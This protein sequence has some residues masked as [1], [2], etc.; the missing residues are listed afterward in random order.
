MAAF[1]ALGGFFVGVATVKSGL[2]TTWLIPVAG[3]LGALVVA[4]VMARPLWGCALL[5][6]SSSVG[7]REIPS[8]PLGL[9][10]VHV[11][12]ALTGLSV[13]AGLWGGRLAAP[14]DLDPWVRRTI[15][16][17]GALVLVV[18]TA[19]VLSVDLT[20][21]AKTATTFAAG[22]LMVLSIGT[23]ARSQGDLRLLVEAFVVGS[24]PLSIQ[25]IT[26]AAQ[27]RSVYSATV[28]VGR[29]S[30]Y[31]AEPNGLGLFCGI[32]ML[33]S[34]GLW[35]WSPSWQ[36]RSV[37][38]AGGVA[39]FLATTALAASLSRGAWLGAGV[40]LVTFAVLYRPV[41]R[42]VARLAV[43][44][45][46]SWFVVAE[47]GVL[48]GLPTILIAR[49]E[50]LLGGESNP[51]DVRPLTWAEAARQ[52]LSSPIIG[53]GPNSFGVL[54]A[55][56]PSRIQFY[57]R[58]H[59]HNGLLTIATETGIL[60]VAAVLCLVL[61]STVATLRVGGRD[62]IRVALFSSL[63]AVSG[64]LLVDY[65]LRNPVLMLT[66]WCVL[67]LLVASIELGRRRQ[68]PWHVPRRPALR[69]HKDES[70]MAA[71]ARTERL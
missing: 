31:F 53:H 22:M 47:S 9:Q 11:L 16:S 37:S 12:T 65:P 23:C 35:I 2:A 71:L 56:W 44:G 41:L 7:N 64:H 61:F 63:V 8:G 68:H 39:G 57:P 24:L 49:A 69:P 34:L 15:L 17:A 60:G 54:S 32:I 26:Q 58:V 25:G 5:L 3:V 40:G 62:P 21:S 43:L 42:I 13:L 18:V 51:Y 4:A 50:T 6:A 52:F 10:V 33:V 36:A 29:P 70:P 67:G 30:G 59:A 28:V 19:T 1:V 66:V 14:R 55:E 45:V 20:R 38:I 48:G 27:A 46:V